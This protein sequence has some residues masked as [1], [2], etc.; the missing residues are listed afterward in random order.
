MKRV[1]TLKGIVALCMAS[2]ALAEGPYV[3]GRLIRPAYGEI[4]GTPKELAEIKAYAVSHGWTVV[5]DQRVGALQTMRVRFPVG[6]SQKAIE[7]YFEGNWPPG[8]GSKFNMI[9][10][11]MH[12]TSP[13]CILLP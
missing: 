4:A 12:T 13:G 8:R 6:T 2:S 11:G 7:G 3:R 10:Y 5:C 9:Y 1:A